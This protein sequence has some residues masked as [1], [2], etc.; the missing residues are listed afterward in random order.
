MVALEIVNCGDG[1][2]CDIVMFRIGM[3]MMFEM[4]VVLG[5]VMGMVMMGIVPI[6]MVQLHNSSS[7]MMDWVQPLYWQH[8]HHDDCSSI[9]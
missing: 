9:L 1:D 8:H 7:M 6:G 5:I 3:V 2:D 4:V